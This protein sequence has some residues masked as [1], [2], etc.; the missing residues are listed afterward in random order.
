MSSVLTSTTRS[1]YDLPVRLNIPLVLVSIFMLHCTAVFGQQF[2]TL[3]CPDPYSGIVNGEAR[4]E[5]IPTSA[6]LNL[7]STIRVTRL[8]KV[9]ISHAASPVVYE[10]W[11]TLENQTS[12]PVISY[13]FAA[14]T[15]STAATPVII[16]EKRNV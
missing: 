11:I 12:H 7:T 8:E 1:L 3:Q 13:S 5:E 2:G 16:F 14:G 4:V 6:I 10:Y 15:L 9:A